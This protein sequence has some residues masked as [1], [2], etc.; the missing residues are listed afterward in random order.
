MEPLT[1][2]AAR[3]VSGDE[4]EISAI[5]NG[6]GRL[7]AE[8]RHGRPVLLFSTEW[9]LRYAGENAQAVTFESLTVS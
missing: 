7:R 9:D 5:G 8:D 3:W 1:Y 6:R 4:S 2:T